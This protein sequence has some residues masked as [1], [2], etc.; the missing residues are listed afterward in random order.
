MGPRVTRAKLGTFA[1]TVEPTAGRR[2]AAIGKWA[3]TY[4]K[5]ADGRWLCASDTWNLDAPIGS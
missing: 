1:I 2:I 3:G 5:R 4:R